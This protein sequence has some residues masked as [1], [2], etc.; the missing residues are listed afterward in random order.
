MKN[1]ETINSE[2]QLIHP[3]AHEVR[4]DDATTEIYRVASMLAHS[5]HDK[6][7]GAL[8]LHES[9][10]EFMLNY[11]GTPDIHGRKGLHQLPGTSRHTKN[12][13]RNYTLGCGVMFDPFSRE[14]CS[15]RKDPNANILDPTDWLVVRYNVLTG[16]LT[17]ETV[18]P[19]IKIQPGD[20]D[21]ITLEIAPDVSYHG[22]Y[23][24]E[25]SVD[26]EYNATNTPISYSHKNYYGRG[27]G[28]SP[29]NT[30]DRIFSEDIA[31]LCEAIDF[32][33]LHT[34]K[35]RLDTYRSIGHIVTT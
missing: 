14:L 26:Q 15:I 4:H 21:R 30:T 32:E 13:D 20:N 7:D 11:V 35:S 18:L 3:L 24:L 10:Q 17:E 23:Q 16:K 34:E 5:R 19:S 6:T 8:N 22:P 25:F 29:E 31:V 33:V 9:L 27:T 1:I 28:S 12:G 2:V